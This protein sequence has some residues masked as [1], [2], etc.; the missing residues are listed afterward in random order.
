[1]YVLRNAFGMIQVFSNM[2][3]ALDAYEKECL[4][5][6]CVSLYNADSGEVVAESW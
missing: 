3:T 2:E 4:F 1:M 5:C 6:E